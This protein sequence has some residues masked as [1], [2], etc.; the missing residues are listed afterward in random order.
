MEFKIGNK[1]IIRKAN[2]NEW[3]YGGDMDDYTPGMI[4]ECNNLDNSFKVKTNHWGKFW[5]ASSEMILQDE[6]NQKMVYET[7]QTRDVGTT[8]PST[9]K[10]KSTIKFNY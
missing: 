4:I 8:S 6:Y 7:E 9:T 1:V 3:V 5:V 10:A 2:S